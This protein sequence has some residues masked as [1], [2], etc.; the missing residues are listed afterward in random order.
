MQIVSIVKT[1]FLGT[2]R[3]YY[4]R[5]LSADF[6][7]GVLRVKETMRSFNLKLTKKQLKKI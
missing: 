5:M 4:F 2:I 3:K 6:F 1:Y 7:R